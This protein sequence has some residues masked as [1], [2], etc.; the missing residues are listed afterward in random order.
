MTESELIARAGT[1]KELGA[2]VAVVG[3]WVW[4]TFPEKPSAEIRQILKDNHFRWSK[5]RNA[6]YFAGNLVERQ[7][8]KRSWADIVDKY[9]MKSLEL[10]D[11]TI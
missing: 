5:N 6:W 4:V 2:E 9:G 10:E 8:P 11:A 3:Q 7:Q 1:A